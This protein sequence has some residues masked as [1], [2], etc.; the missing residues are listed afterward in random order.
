[1]RI[2]LRK[3]DEITTGIWLHPETDF[4]A[5]ELQHIFADG[6]NIHGHMVGMPSKTKEDCNWYPVILDFKDMP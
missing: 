5:A 2:T 4:E 6:I 1:M 3:K